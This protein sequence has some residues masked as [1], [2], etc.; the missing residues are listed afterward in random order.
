MRLTSHLAIAA[1]LLLPFIASCSGENKPTEAEI[2]AALAAELP[3]YVKVTS[4][5]I[6]AMENNGSEVDPNY[7]ARFTATMETQARL[8]VKDG[9]AGDQ[10]LVKEVTAAGH[11]TE[12]F[13]KS[14]SELYQGGWR[15]RLL[16]DGNPVA[17]LGRPLESF[18]PTPTLIR[19]SE[20]EKAYFAALEAANAEFNATIKGLPIHDM[21]TEFYNTK[22]EWAGRF[23]LHEVI[24]SRSEKRTNEEFIVHAKY[25]YRKP[26]DSKAAGD[27]RRTFSFQKLD[28][29]WQVVNMGF[30]GSGKI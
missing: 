3:D 17:T 12:L 26:K 24:A 4:F 21:I 8:F 6:E 9:R 11:S 20:E 1:I 15:H 7:V 14:A 16:I 28:G 5:D 2:S 30:A 13:G 18:A 23:A 22:S 19:G 25:S 29:Q 27:D 10:Q